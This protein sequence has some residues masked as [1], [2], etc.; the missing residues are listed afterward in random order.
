MCNI[1]H[2]SAGPKN[3]PRAPER[4]PGD[5]R[6]EGI[7]KWLAD[8]PDFDLLLGMARYGADLR[9]TAKPSQGTAP[10]RVERRHEQTISAQLTKELELGWLTT[11]P[12]FPGAES[13][14]NA[15]IFAKDEPG[16]VRRLTDYSDRDAHGRMQGANALVDKESLGDA[17]MD[18]PLQLARAVRR[19][20]R[21]TGRTPVML[22]RD[23]S[24]AYRRI[25]VRSEDIP[26]LHTVWNGVHMW[27]TRLPFG[28]AAAAHHCCKLTAAIAAALTQRMNGNAEAL[29]YVDD[30][31]IVSDPLHA[32]AAEALLHEML[33]DIGM[34]IT[35]EKAEASGTWSS[36]A[37]W[38][39]YTHDTVRRTHAL[40]DGKVPELRERIRAAMQASSVTQPALA[41]LRGKLNHVANIH[42]PARAHMQALH[43]AAR[44]GDGRTARMT[45]EAK[46]ELQWWDKALDWM[47][48]QAKMADVPHAYSKCLAT[49]A[50]LSGLGAV[51]HET[52][53]N[54]RALATPVA[55][56]AAPFP[57]RA[58]PKHMMTLEAIA[59]LIAIC[60]WGAGLR[61]STIWLQ[62][63]NQA[64]VFALRRG[65]SKCPATNAVLQ[66]IFVALI[67]FQLQ[68]CPFHVR[69]ED[70]EQADELSR[71]WEPCR[72]TCAQLQ[73]GLTD[74]SSALL[75]THSS[76]I[77]DPTK[78]PRGIGCD[79]LDEPG[80]RR[81][82]QCA[83]QPSS[84]S[85]SA[86]TLQQR[87]QWAAQASKQH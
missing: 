21:A 7:S 61:G 5:I 82:K 49:D 75:N 50:S 4:P 77:R 31:I 6:P 87:T 15:P 28:H 1:P 74:A 13:T 44:A 60:E 29:A 81:K 12:P 41:T 66:D 17:P 64:L 52:R 20:W 85:H 68:I 67:R 36:T 45:D 48:S 42:H 2:V 24:K 65:R 70:N 22:V 69:S 51:L 35:P 78:R 10:N 26:H 58:E 72:S 79:S 9:H 80:S 57:H 38:I 19:L 8:A 46:R 53:G 84:R 34:P 59:V 83:H 30:F 33:A 39:G 73:S 62:L 71:Q 54:S 43:R 40:R 18:R 3:R 55:R 76:Q 37:D 11:T 27:D 86:D 56:L 47:P 63:D 16:K 25:A 14:R 32:K 23:I